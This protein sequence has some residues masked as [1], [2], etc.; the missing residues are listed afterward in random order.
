MGEAINNGRKTLQS[1]AETFKKKARP[2]IRDAYELRVP[3][4]VSL[5]DARQEMNRKVDDLLIDWHY[6]NKPTTV[7]SNP[8]GSKLIV[9][10]YS[11]HRAR[12]FEA[13]SITTQSTE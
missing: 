9:N 13:R 11:S 7:S 12:L 2:I 8:L 4:E 3:I 1:V 10:I 5:L 6:T